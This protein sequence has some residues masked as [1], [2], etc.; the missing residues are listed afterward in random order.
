MLPKRRIHVHDLFHRGVEASEEH[1]ADDENAK[2]VLLFPKAFGQ[3]LSLTGI[4]NDYPFSGTLRQAIRVL[5][6]IRLRVIQAT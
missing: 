5:N 1:V 4:K 6:C 3:S 2:G